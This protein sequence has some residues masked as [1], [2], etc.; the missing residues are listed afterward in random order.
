MHAIAHRSLVLQQLCEGLQ[1]YNLIDIMEKNREVC[2]SLF[3]VQGGDEKVISKTYSICI[4]V[5]KDVTAQNNS[6]FFF[7]YCMLFR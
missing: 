7:L 2:R 1:L 5:V 4:A 3:V 6:N